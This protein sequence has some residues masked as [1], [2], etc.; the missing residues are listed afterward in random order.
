MS[1]ARLKR[2]FDINTIGPFMCAKQA[3]IHMAYCY[4][5][6]GGVIVNISSVAANLGAAERA[7]DYAASKGAI[8]VLTKGLGDEIAADHVRVVEVRPGVIDTGIHAKE[9]A[10]SRFKNLSNSLPMKR[11]GPAEEVADTI[12]YLMSDKASYITSTSIDVS[13]AGASRFPKDQ[14]HPLLLCGPKS[15]PKARGTRRAQPKLIADRVL[16]VSTP[17]PSLHHGLKRSSQPRRI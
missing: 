13:G 4:G 8:D 17:C 7:V 11:P 5:G 16:D 10:S 3:A 2:M 14:H 15:S 12:L 1:Y 6:A 9:N